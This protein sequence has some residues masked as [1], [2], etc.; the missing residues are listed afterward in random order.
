MT[1]GE[2]ASLV[3]EMRKAQKAYCQ[4]RSSRALEKAR[5]FERSVDD[6]LARRETKSHC[7]RRKK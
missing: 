5:E 4:S 3:S 2:F 1:T 6:L 7:A